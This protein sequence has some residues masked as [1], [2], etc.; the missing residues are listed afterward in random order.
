MD[1]G[2]VDAAESGR[3]AAQNRQQRGLGKPETFTFLGFTFFCGKSRQGRFLL[4]RKTRGERCGAAV[5]RPA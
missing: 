5:S 4:Q 1:S 3:W 2:R